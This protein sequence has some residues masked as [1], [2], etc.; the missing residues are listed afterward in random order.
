MSSGLKIFTL[1]GTVIAM[2]FAILVASLLNKWLNPQ[3]FTCRLDGP[4]ETCFQKPGGPV[5]GL[6]GGL[7]VRC[8]QRWFETPRSMVFQ[9]VYSWEHHRTRY[10]K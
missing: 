1:F 7:Q 2:I 6:L 5:L 8:P 4:P 3:D 9:Y 10:A